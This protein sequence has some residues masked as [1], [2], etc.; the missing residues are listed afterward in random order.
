MYPACATEHEAVEC[1]LYVHD[2]AIII[3]TARGDT[4]GSVVHVSCAAALRGIMAGNGGGHSV[5]ASDARAK[6]VSG[7]KAYLPGFCITLRRDH[8]YETVSGANHVESEG[9]Y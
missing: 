5:F 4:L 3:M 2:N 7:A 6:N 9:A 1:V 8:H